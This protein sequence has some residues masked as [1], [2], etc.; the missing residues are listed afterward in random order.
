MVENSYC[1]V[2]LIVTQT[3]VMLKWVCGYSKKKW[4]VILVVLEI[5]LVKERIEMFYLLVI[6][7]MGVRYP[8]SKLSIGWIPTIGNV[9]MLEVTL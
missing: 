2:P 6:L 8:T 9:L 4:G 5:S 7:P 3:T 1:L